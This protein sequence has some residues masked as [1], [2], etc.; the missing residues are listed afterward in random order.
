MLQ[1]PASVPTFSILEEDLS[2]VY[3]YVYS[4]IGN[5]DEPMTGVHLKMSSP[6]AVDCIAQSLP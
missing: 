4:L 5:D 1:T 6:G 3:G 2:S